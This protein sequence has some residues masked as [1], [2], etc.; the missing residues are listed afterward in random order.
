MCFDGMTR[1][2]IKILVVVFIS[3]VYAKQLPA[4][5]TLCYMQPGEAD[6]KNPKWHHIFQINNC[7]V[8]RL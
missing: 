2:V 7:P 5:G 3:T 1:L 4:S 8:E 6:M